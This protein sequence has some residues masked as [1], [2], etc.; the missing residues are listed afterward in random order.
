MEQPT[1]PAPQPVPAPIDWNPLPADLEFR[2]QFG[3]SLDR[4]LQF[5]ESIT[6]SATTALSRR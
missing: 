5:F 6:G 2:K 1:E 4:L 3:A